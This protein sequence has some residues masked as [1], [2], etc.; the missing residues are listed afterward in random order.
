MY[1]QMMSP[2]PLPMSMQTQ[3]TNTRFCLALTQL[4]TQSMNSANAKLTI[5]GI[6]VERFITVN[7]SDVRLFTIDGSNANLTIGKNITLVGS[8]TGYWSPYLI[9]V[10]R[11][12]FTMR[13]G[14][15][16]TGHTGWA[17]VS[18]GTVRVEGINAS[19]KMDGG[20]ITENAAYDAVVYVTA[21]A[22]FEMSGG[23]ITGNQGSAK[24]DN[25]TEVFINDA[26][27]IFRLSGNAKI[28][29]LMLF[30]NNNTTR[31]TVTIVGNYS[32]TV[33]TLHLSGNQYANDVAPL[34]TNAPVIVNGTAGVIS[35][36]NNGGLGNFSYNM[37]FWA[38]VSIRATHELNASG[39]LVLK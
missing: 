38:G 13:D 39:V 29:R 19:F 22:T 37:Q 32:G 4:G 33:T 5:L 23:S 8:S 11:G 25:G 24:N 35:M 28:G 26:N 15:K 14:S 21:G 17:F 2:P 3:A 20:E 7:A 18:L 36:F 31:S 10:Q 6:G 34:W 9:Y 12:N 27:C 1:R 30:A 16:I